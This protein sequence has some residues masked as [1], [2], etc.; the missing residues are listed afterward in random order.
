V[1]VAMGMDTWLHGCVAAWILGY[2]T[3][4]VAGGGFGGHGH[5]DGGALLRARN[6]NHLRGAESVT[7]SGEKWVAD[8]KQ[9]AL[10]MD[11]YMEIRIWIWDSISN[12]FGIVRCRHKTT[13][14]VRRVILFIRTEQQKAVLV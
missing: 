9:R 4:R 3:A 8:R 12:I 11:L 14:C 6:V 2:L 5:P 10:S 1:R 13:I 7:K